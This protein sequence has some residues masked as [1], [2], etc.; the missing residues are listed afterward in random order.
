M[1]WYHE[2]SRYERLLCHQD[3]QCVCVQASKEKLDCYSQMQEVSWNLYFI[4]EKKIMISGY[5]MSRVV[6]IWK[7]AYGK[8]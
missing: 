7:E 6:A 3:E 2:A 8:Q 1:A 4:K 5:L